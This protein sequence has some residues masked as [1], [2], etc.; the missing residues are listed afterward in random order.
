MFEPTTFPIA[1]SGEPSNADC[2]ETIN[3]G[4]DVPN[5]TTV[6]PITN[7]DNLAL[8][9]IPTAP[10]TRKSPPKISAASPIMTNPN[11]SIT[12]VHYLDFLQTSPEI[13]PLEVLAYVRAP[14]QSCYEKLNSV[15]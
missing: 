9:A 15:N 7:F 3:S 8:A 2:N 4:A 11:S 10:R 5:D 12:S 13:F 1:I 14:F 6:I